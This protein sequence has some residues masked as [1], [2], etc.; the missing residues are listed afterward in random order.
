MWFFQVTVASHAI[1][2]ARRLPQRSVS[3]RGWSTNGR[4]APDRG[5]EPAAVT[6]CGRCGAARRLTPPQGSVHGSLLATAS[7]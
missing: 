7:L 6:L 4:R 3:A 5:D 2:E 1:P